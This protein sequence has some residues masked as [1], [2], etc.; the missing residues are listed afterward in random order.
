MTTATHTG[1]PTKS[2][3]EVFF[4]LLYS[5][6]SRTRYIVAELVIFVIPL[7]RLLRF[8]FRMRYETKDFALTA[9]AKA[10]LNSDL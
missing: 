8:V 10:F 9:I 2:P 5:L 6:V 1:L 7:A 4:E 3:F